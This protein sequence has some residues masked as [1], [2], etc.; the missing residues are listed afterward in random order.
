MRLWGVISGVAW[1]TLKN[2]ITTPSLLLP[3]LM[4]IA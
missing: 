4:C 1:R 2:V 3:S